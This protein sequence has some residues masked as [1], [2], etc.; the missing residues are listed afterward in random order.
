MF[1]ASERA[2]SIITDNVTTKPKTTTAENLFLLII[3][4]PSFEVIER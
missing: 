2:G 4:P 1:R 3:S